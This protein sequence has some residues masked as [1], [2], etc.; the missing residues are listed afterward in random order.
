[1]RQ[2]MSQLLL[3]NSVKHGIA[4]FR[5]ERNGISF[6]NPQFSPAKIAIFRASAKYVHYMEHIMP[7]Y[8]EHIM[9]DLSRANSR[10]IVRA[11]VQTCIPGSS[12]AYISLY[13]KAEASDIFCT[14]PISAPAKTPS[15]GK[16][17]FW[18]LFTSLSS[19]F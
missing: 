17:T 7:H 8:M 18:T 4:A 11:D 10:Q 2:N 16:R 3:C 5:E 13:I 12:S 19:S 15:S 9:Y 1:M 6:R 14:F